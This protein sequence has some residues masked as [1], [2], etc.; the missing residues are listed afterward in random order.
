MTQNTTLTNRNGAPTDAIDLAGV[1]HVALARLN[2]DTISVN[3]LADWLYDHGAA[4]LNEIERIELAERL[5]TR[6]RFLIG[7]GALGL[8]MITG[9]GA[10]EEVAAPTAT[11]ATTRTVTDDTGTV[12]EIPAR[13]QRIVAV[14]DLAGVRAL[15]LG[16]SVIGLQGDGEA[17]REEITSLFSL[18][19]VANIGNYGEPNLELIVSLKPDLIIDMCSDGT[20]W[21]DA[22]QVSRLR[23]IAPFLAV[24]NFVD[25]HTATARM[26]ELLGEAATVSPDDLKAKFESALAPVRALIQAAGPNLTAA[27]AFTSNPTQSFY[28][29]GPTA[30]PLTD[31]LT[32]AGVRWA[33][34]A[35]EAQRNGG[36]IEFSAEVAPAKLA[37]DLLIFVE[38]LVNMDV[39][40][41]NTIPAAREGQLVLMPA[42]WTVTYPSYIVVAETYAT[43]LG[44]LS[45]LSGDLV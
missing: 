40:L 43:L 29:Y 13:P 42:L 9:C 24:E 8:G 5:I 19:G 44:A 15:A 38:A 17:F 6:R 33:P 21:S 23:Q 25:V 41:I 32:M 14:N 4:H 39:P 10:D 26:A 18:N 31:V 30:V 12:V 45:P 11:V 35:D 34:V 3:D 20:P 28:A 7:A 2:L 16:A 37:A 36:D 27:V 1:D 22:D